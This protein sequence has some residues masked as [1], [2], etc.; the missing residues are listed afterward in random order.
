MEPV[1]LEMTLERPARK[2][3]GDR[4]AYSWDGQQHSQYFPQSIS[5][6][7][8]ISAQTLIVTVALGEDS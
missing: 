2:S 8:G 7:D 1:K 5:R 4:Y 3:G 6:Q